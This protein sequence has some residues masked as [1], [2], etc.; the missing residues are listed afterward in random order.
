MIPM[1]A[2]SSYTETDGNNF[3]PDIELN[4]DTEIDLDKDSAHKLSEELVELD[5]D[6]ADPDTIAR[7]GSRT[8]TDLVRL[9][10]QEIGR[11]PL[12]ERDEEVSE[13]Q[14]VQPQAP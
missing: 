13:A 14:K 8:T 2:N 4:L 3:S 11:V 7:R 9:Y 6:S 5:L 10:L 12:L 1:L